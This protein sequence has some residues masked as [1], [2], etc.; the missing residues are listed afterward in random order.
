[1]SS[2]DFQKN[3]GVG[4]PHIKYIYLCVNQFTCHNHR[5]I[6]FCFLEKNLTSFA[7]AHG[8]NKPCAIEKAW[9]VS[10][11]GEKQISYQSVRSKIRPKQHK[12]IPGNPLFQLTVTRMVWHVK[13]GDEKWSTPLRGPEAIWYVL[14]S[15]GLAWLDILLSF[16][17]G[18]SK[19]WTGS[20]VYKQFFTPYSLVQV[21]LAVQSLN[22]KH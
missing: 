7:L 18:R 16:V 13:R 1:M 11:M 17:S 2:S 6:S 9:I 10:A 3:P 14:C 21:I 5:V 22:Y 4:D 12:P 8:E 20:S 19:W 15:Y